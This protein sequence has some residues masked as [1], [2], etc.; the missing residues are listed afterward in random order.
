MHSSLFVLFSSLVLSP[1]PLSSASTIFFSASTIRKEESG[2]F[3]VSY[4]P[5]YRELFAQCFSMIEK[6]L[7]LSLMRV[8]L[9]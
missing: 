2:S 6:D 8:L 4:V 9:R 7:R 5:R 3:S 1:V